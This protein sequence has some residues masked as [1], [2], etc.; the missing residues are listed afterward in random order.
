M[1]VIPSHNPI[2][3]THMSW[4]LD[5]IFTDPT[6]NGIVNQ[7]LVTTMVQVAERTNMNSQ[8][9]QDFLNLLLLIGKKLIGVWKH[10]QTYS[11]I[12]DG[13]IEEAN[14]TEPVEKQKIQR[15]SYSLDL[16]LEFDELFVQTKS[17]LDYLVKVPMPILGRNV[18]PLRTFKGKGEAVVN[19]L[20]RN[21]PTQYTQKARLIETMLTDRHLGWLD[22]AIETRNRINHFQDGGIDFRI[23]IV[24]K[25][26]KDGKEVIHVPAWQ[27]DATVRSAMEITWSNLFM[28][29]EDFIGGF[30]LM[31]LPENYAVIH[32]VSLIDNVRSA[33]TFFSSQAAAE[34]ALKRFGGKVESI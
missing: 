2:E 23:F 14:K 34:E 32:K 25:I 17:T 9:K 3:V 6:P 10:L 33:W 19:A 29:C 20:R 8:E 11:T 21:M 24:I 18:W 1:G 28:L 22:T 5:E 15:V 30:L 27:E 13:L 16:F 31:R 26:M 4:R 7:R 12:E